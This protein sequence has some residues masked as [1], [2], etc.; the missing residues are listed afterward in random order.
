MKRYEDCNHPSFQTC[1]VHLLHP[2]NSYPYRGSITV[3]DYPGTRV[4][5]ASSLF[6]PTPCAAWTDSRIARPM[7]QSPRTA[8]ETRWYKL[9]ILRPKPIQYKFG[10]ILLV[11][12][13]QTINNQILY[14]SYLQNRL[15]TLKSAFYILYHCFLR[16]LDCTVY[17]GR[18][19][20]ALSSEGIPLP[21]Y[22]TKPLL[23]RP[24][25][26]TSALA[27][28]LPPSLPRSLVPSPS[29]LSVS[30]ASSQSS[31]RQTF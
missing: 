13:R 23:L 11:V 24:L 29:F 26:K 12:Y 15:G 10:T 25:R 28:S 20:L 1:S 22:A 9:P 2:R 19:S 16:V 14:Y 7:V 6:L 31:L 21:G 3:S 30:I 5:T 27:P 17:K 4:Q 18:Y 8:K